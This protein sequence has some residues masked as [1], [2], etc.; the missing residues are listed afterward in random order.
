MSLSTDGATP[1]S[2][3]AERVYEVLNGRPVRPSQF[4]PNASK[5]SLVFFY[6]AFPYAV[7]ELV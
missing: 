5:K 4:P 1:S 3:A 7:H 2:A 6:L